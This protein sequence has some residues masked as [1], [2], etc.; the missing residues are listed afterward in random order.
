MKTTDTVQITKRLPFK[1]MVALITMIAS[2]GAARA[3][4]TTFNGREFSLSLF[5]G[6]ADKQNDTDF[7]PGAGVTYFL[8]RHLGAGAFTHWENWEGTFFDN[9]SAE[10]YF[11][12]PLDRLRLA[13][14]GLVAFGY[15]FETEETFEGLGAG[16]DFRFSERWGAFGDLRWQ[17]NN[18]T[19]DG[20]ALRLGVRMR[21]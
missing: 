17:F 5:G 9:I 13:P 21:F 3:A 16:A 19:D 14:Y 12:F 1:A 18:D 11:R 4:D 7:A 2:L 20:V 8:T 10:G 15:S 6:W